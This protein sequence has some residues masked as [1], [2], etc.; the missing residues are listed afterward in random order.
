MLIYYTLASGITLQNSQ[1][2]DLTNSSFFYTLASSTNLTMPTNLVLVLKLNNSDLNE[3]KSRS[4]LSTSPNDTFLS[5]SEITVR[6]TSGNSIVPIPSTNAMA[7]S[8]YVQDETPPQLKQHRK[9]G[10]SSKISH[11][12][13]RLY[14]QKDDMESTSS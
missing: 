10:I 11:L 2:Q 8:N 1:S 7:V 5:L 6:G 4:R 3:I 12:N 13:G 14:F 9:C